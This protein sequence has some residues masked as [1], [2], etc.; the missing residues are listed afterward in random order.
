MVSGK[1]ADFTIMAAIATNLMSGVHVCR[2]LWLGATLTPLG[3]V[4]TVTD[5]VHFRLG[6]M[7]IHWTCRP[8]YIILCFLTIVLL[9]SGVLLA[10]T[11]I[12]NQSILS[13]DHMEFANVSCNVIPDFEHM[14]L[15]FPTIAVLLLG[16]LICLAVAAKMRY[17]ERQD[18]F[19]L[20]HLPHLNARLW[21]T[22]KLAATYCLIWTMAFL[23]IFYASVAL[24]HVFT[25]LCS[26]QAIYVTVNS[27][28][29][30]P[31]LDLIHQ[32]HE[33]KMEDLKA[34]QAFVC[35]PLKRTTV[36]QPRSHN[37]HTTGLV[38]TTNPTARITQANN[39]NSMPKHSTTLA[40]M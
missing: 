17:M 16:Q 37:T 2:Q 21:I 27:I 28:F 1:M 18:G 26:L 34:E 14:Y 23:A 20:A 40:N 22:V 7:T 30:R 5:N 35:R 9:P 31:V 39:V 36:V 32:W 25:L 8:F 19:L 10:G 6:R 24:W 13:E 29:S 4:K 15:F 33:D 3:S 11:R 12:P 38:T